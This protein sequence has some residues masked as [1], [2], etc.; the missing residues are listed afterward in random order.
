MKHLVFDDAANALYLFQF[1]KGTIETAQQH[2]KFMGIP[3]FNSI[4]VRLKLYQANKNSNGNMEF[5]FHKGT[6]ETGKDKIVINPI[7]DI[8]I[9]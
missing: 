3:Y 8:S 6:I 9:P 5:Q 2:M 4:K 7:I 1:H